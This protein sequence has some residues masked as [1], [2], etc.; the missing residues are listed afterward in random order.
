M[1]LLLFALPVLVIPSMALSQYVYIPGRD[2]LGKVDIYKDGVRIEDYIEP[3]MIRQQQ[4][5]TIPKGVDLK[6]VI[7]GMPNVPIRVYD[8]WRDQKIQG[9]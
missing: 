4:Q 6:Y 8:S 5:I 9:R 7:T 1:R 2:N 3:L